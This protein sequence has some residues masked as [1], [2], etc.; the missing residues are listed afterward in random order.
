L[1]PYIFGAK[2]DR[3]DYEKGFL[4]T[5]EDV[6]K[7]GTVAR[8]KLKGLRNAYGEGVLEALT[9]GDFIDARAETEEKPVAEQLAEPF[10]E[11]GT[12]RFF[13]VLDVMDLQADFG[14]PN[15]GK[16]EA[17]ETEPPGAQEDRNNAD[18]AADIGEA[19]I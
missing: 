5:R 13:D 17:G 14:T 18:S 3:Y 6:I 1:R 12:A 4:A 9:Y 19:I 10:F 7:P 16:Q 2:E 15:G 8:S 11:D